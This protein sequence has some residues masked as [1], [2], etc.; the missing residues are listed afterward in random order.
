MFSGRKS[1]RMEARSNHEL[2]VAG[3][4]EAVQPEAELLEENKPEPTVRSWYESYEEA[5]SKSATLP[6]VRTVVPPHPSA[7]LPR[8][9]ENYV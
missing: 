1:Q 4:L 6:L 8:I 9:K 7:T 3:T 2:L 5:V